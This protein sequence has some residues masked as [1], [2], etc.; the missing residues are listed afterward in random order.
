MPYLFPYVIYP[1]L[2]AAA[3]TAIAAAVARRKYKKMARKKKTL[4]IMFIIFTI[5][6]GMASIM[7]F[8][9]FLLD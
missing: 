1:W 8:I 9:A 4:A 7:G 5:V 6:S 2:A 3:V